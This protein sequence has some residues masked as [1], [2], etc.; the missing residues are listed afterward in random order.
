MNITRHLL[1]WILPLTPLCI[2]LHGNA[3]FLIEPEIGTSVPVSIGGKISVFSPARIGIRVG[4]GFVP[5]G[6]VSLANNISLAFGAYNDA[7]ADLIRAAAA[8]AL[9]VSTQAVYRFGLRS[10]FE[11][12][13]GYSYLSGSGRSA[14]VTLIEAATGRSFPSAPGTSEAELHSSTHNLNFDVGYRWSIRDRWQ[15]GVAVGLVKPFASSSG[16]NIETLG[17]IANKVIDQA[18]DEYLSD[19]YRSYVYIPTV[20]VSVAYPF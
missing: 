9:Y 5:S 16:A 14:T 3:G 1:A 11:I 10:G 17:P 2:P 18:V 13:L 4:A 8:N 6:Y 20:S 7:T 15:L 19:M 12:A